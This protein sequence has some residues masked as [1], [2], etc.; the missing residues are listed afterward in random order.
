MTNKPGNEEAPL[1]AYYARRRAK[2]VMTLEEM[3]LV[4]EQYKQEL[5]TDGRPNIDEASKQRA[6]ALRQRY[7]GLQAN[8]RP[9]LE[10][11]TMLKILLSEELEP[12]VSK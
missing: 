7:A 1:K 12:Q 5:G 9:L 10:E 8:L 4:N 11:V 2:L 3:E 6:V